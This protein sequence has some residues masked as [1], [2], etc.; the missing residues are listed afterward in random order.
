MVHC[1]YPWVGYGVVSISSNGPRH[2][3]K[4]FE[5][6][7]CNRAAPIA[8]IRRWVAKT[9]RRIDDADTARRRLKRASK[10]IERCRLTPG[11][12]AQHHVQ[13]AQALRAEY[14]L[15]T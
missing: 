6:Q 7:A 3:N 13:L 15:G 14:G 10:D 2:M 5:Q 12:D 11:C 4:P 8:D 1:V 9:C